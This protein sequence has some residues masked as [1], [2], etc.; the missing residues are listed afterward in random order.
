MVKIKDTNYSQVP[1]C[2]NHFSLLAPCT[3]RK[4]NYEINLGLTHTM[5]GTLFIKMKKVGY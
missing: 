4:E 3:L 2:E 1:E 5:A